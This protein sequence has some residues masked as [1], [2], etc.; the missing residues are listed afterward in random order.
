[1]AA[2]PKPCSESPKTGVVRAGGGRSHAFRLDHIDGHGFVVNQ[3]GN[4]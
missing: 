1:V 4:T 3:P 2:G